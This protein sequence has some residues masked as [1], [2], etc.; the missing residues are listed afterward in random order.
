MG[1]LSYVPHPLTSRRERVGN[2]FHSMFF[3]LNGQHPGR[4][5]AGMGPPSV[6]LESFSM[7][8]PHRPCARAAGRRGSGRGRGR[9]GCAAHRRRAAGAAGAGW[10]AQPRALP[11]SCST[12]AGGVPRRL[13]P[14]RIRR[15][16]PQPAPSA[17]PRAFLSPA[18]IAPAPTRPSAAASPASPAAGGCAARAASRC[19]CPS[20]CPSGSPSCSSAVPPLLCLPPLSLSP[21]PGA[22]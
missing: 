19:C 4:G 20:R 6:A 16:P 12:P 3:L 21:R 22:V 11:R 9:R 2:A 18:Q 13:G 10:A 5:P 7:G 15:R 17:R 14:R 8:G 1:T